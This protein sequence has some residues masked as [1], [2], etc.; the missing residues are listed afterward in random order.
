MRSG[1]RSAVYIDS[2]VF[3]FSFYVKRSEENLFKF[4]ALF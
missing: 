3:F 2:K 1:I 4:Q